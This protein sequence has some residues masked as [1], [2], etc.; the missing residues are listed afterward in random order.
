MN[1]NI[2][3]N[4][5]SVKIYLRR[6]QT[7][8]LPSNLSLSLA[9]ITISSLCSI[10]ACFGVNLL[11]QRVLVSWNFGSFC[12]DFRTIFEK[13]L[14]NFHRGIVSFLRFERAGNAVD[15]GLSGVWE[16]PDGFT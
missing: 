13:G 7:I 16:G 9:S 11:H 1:I 5:I 14:I 8:S 2:Y 4:P 12:P 10:S 15:A 6:D 3:H